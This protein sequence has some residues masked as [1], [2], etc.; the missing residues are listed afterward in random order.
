VPQATDPGRWRPLSTKDQIATVYGIEDVPVRNIAPQG[1][2]DFRLVDP[3]STK[4]YGPAL[5]AERS[6]LSLGPSRYDLLGKTETDS[7]FNIPDKTHIRE[8]L[9]VNGSR[10]FYLDDVP[11]RLEDGALRRVDTLDATKNFRKLPCR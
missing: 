7:F 5:T 6:E 10:T 2:P 11:Y 9:E 3:F 4:P 1:K 8:V